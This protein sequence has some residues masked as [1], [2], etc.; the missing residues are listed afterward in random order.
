M[1]SSTFGE[2]ENSLKGVVN[3]ML[4]RSRLLDQPQRRNG[5]ALL[6]SGRMGPP[7]HRGQ[8]SAVLGGMCKWKE[9][10]IA[11]AGKRV[12]S[13]I[14]TATPRTRSCMR[15]AVG[16][17][18]SAIPPAYTEI[19]GRSYQIRRW[20]EPQL[21]EPA[22][23]SRFGPAGDQRRWRRSSNHWNHQCIRFSC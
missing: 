1:Q 16:K 18:A 12:P 17:E 6:Q 2:T 19:C 10:G 7:G 22:P 9:G 21:G 11:H 15:C 3:L 14:S 13:L 20:V 23:A 4:A 5:S 8:R